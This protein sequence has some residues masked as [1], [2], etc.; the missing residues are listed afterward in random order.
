GMLMLVAGVVQIVH[1][2]SLKTWGQFLV[3][4]V[5]GI[6]YALAGVV[7][8]VNPLLASAVLTLLLAAALVAGGAMRIWIAFKER[9]EKGWGWML[10]GGIV[11]LLAGL[12]IAVKWPVSSLFV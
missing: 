11:T 2:F 12:V 1:A 7:A 3:W 10:A 8:F 5:S 6:V 4:V 9:P